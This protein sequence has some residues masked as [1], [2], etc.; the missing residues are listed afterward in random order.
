[1]NGLGKIAEIIKENDNF[2][3]T[4]HERPDGDC[5]GSQLAMGL[6]LKKLDKK[7]KMINQDEPPEVFDFLPLFDEIK[8]SYSE[9]DRFNVSVI[10]DCGDWCRIGNVEEVAKKSPVII[11]IDHH[12]GDSGVGT[13]N[14][15]NP[16][17]SSTGE[18]LFDLINLMDLEID[19]DIAECLYLAIL[20][21]TGRFRFPNTTSDT[22]FAVSCLLKTGIDG[23]GIIRLL[24]EQGTP[25]QLRLF[26]EIIRTVETDRLNKIAWCTFDKKM[27]KKHPE[28][29]QKFETVTVFKLLRTIKGFKAHLIF[30]EKENGTKVN[31]RSVPGLDL[32][33]IA[34]ELGG[35]GHPQACACFIEDEMVKVKKKVIAEVE[36]ALEEYFSQR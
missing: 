18:I 32:S 3:I 4:T 9:K 2:V 24:S 30:T 23:E 20:Q 15:I 34:R 22:H 12:K 29:S 33:D 28:V 7:F 21:D 14:Y 27:Q 5:I 31:F 19:R 11:N 25:E 16:H 35:G 6:I 26:G 10:L 8:T 17:K 13:Y 1:M 36:K